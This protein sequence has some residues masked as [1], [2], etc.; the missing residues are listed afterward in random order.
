MRVQQW[1]SLLLLIASSSLQHVHAVIEGDGNCILFSFVPFTFAGVF[2]TSSFS[3]RY[4]NQTNVGFSHVAA[5]LLAMDHFNNRN[6]SM[7][8][9]LADFT[10]CTVQFDMNKSLFFDTGSVSH[11][12]SKSFW[13]EEIDPCAMAGPFNDIPAID[14]SVLALSA[15]IP[16]VAHRAFNLRV[17]SNDLSPYT[18][19]VFPGTQ[20]SAKNLVDYLL[21]KERTNYIGVLY[22][23]TETG[24]HR[25]EALSIELN[26]NQIKWTSSGYDILNDDTATKES[27]LEALKRIKDSK[28]RTIVVAMEF[29]FVE[30]ELLADAAEELE[31]N[32]GEYFWVFFS[33]FD[34]SKI[35]SDE[36]NLLKLLSGSALVL[37]FSNAYLNESHPFRSAW[38][39]QGKTEIDRLNAANPINPD[40]VGYIFA[41][42]DWFNTTDMEYG[43]GKFCRSVRLLLSVLLAAN[44]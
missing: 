1:Y 40:E 39:S 22:A 4:T 6:A 8:S 11:F 41:S 10:N 30:M 31:M 34:A 15:E 44:S 7:V 38:G 23:L 20:A 16:L 37:P 26:K 25:R 9:E 19:Q 24:V 17:A 5:A 35:Y 21:F 3:G 13:N 18:S 27:F 2:P 28:Y 12:A 29:P 14:L 43:S 33:I 42:D 36:P 32:E